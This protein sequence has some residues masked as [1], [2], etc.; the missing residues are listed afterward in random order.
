MSHEAWGESD[1]PAWRSEPVQITE[2]LLR[3]PAPV[4]RGLIVNMPA[5][6]MT[7]SGRLFQAAMW[8]EYAMTWHGHRTKS[9][10]GQEWCEKIGRWTYAECIRRSRVNVYLAR[11]LNRDFRKPRSDWC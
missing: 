3:M 8:R 4:T 2:I 7:L 9:G 6:G 1:D 5:G 10:I 11:R